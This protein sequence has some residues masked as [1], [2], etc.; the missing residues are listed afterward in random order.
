ME[1]KGWI[2][3]EV[4]IALE[5]KGVTCKDCRKYTRCTPAHKS[6][7]RLCPCFREVETTPI[8]HDACIKR[9]VFICQ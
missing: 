4:L 1:Y 6:C 9:G 5:N 8:H 3:E 2:S 7:T